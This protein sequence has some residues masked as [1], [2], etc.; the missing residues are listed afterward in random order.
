MLLMFHRAKA[1]WSPLALPG[2]VAWYQPKGAASLA[3]SYVNLAN[4]GTYDAAPVAGAPAFDA[5]IGWTFDGTNPLD[6]G[7]TPV[8]GNAMQW[9]FRNATQDTYIGYYKVGARFDIAP[10]RSSND[11][12]YGSGGQRGVAPRL[13]Y[14]TVGVAAQQGYR[15]GV[16]DGAAI[17]AW[18]A[19]ASGTVWVGGLSGL[20]APYNFIGEVSSFVFCSSLTGILMAQ[21][22]DWMY[23]F[24]ITT[25]QIIC[26]GDSL[27]YG[28]GATHG[29]NDYPTQMQALLGGT[30][31]WRV[32]N[33]GTPSETLA[34][35]EANAAATV[36]IQYETP[37]TEN[38]CIIWGGTNDLVLVGVATTETR[39]QTYCNS[40]RAA[41]WKV[42]AVTCLPRNEANPFE[43]N[44]QAYNTWIRAQGT[45][46]YDALVDIAADPRIG[47]AGDN[48]DLTYYDADQTHLNNAGYAV[49]AAL[50]LAQVATL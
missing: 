7:I 4:P 15:N 11:V 30:T 14:G 50:A 24:A 12:A 29:V 16:A 18:T 43:A 9:R 6:T 28:T 40:R 37:R 45:G 5:L 25:P 48:T 44:R 47:D 42:I 49:V 13:R 10:N 8:S 36:D 22:A 19:A 27:T 1:A 35:M 32:N 26:D 38:I 46:L 3:A 17:A 23:Q 39:L 33:Q 2:L 31:A 34:Q 20:G 41:G 21:L